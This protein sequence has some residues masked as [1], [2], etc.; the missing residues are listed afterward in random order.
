MITLAG[1]LAT[2]LIL[3]GVD[4]RVCN[5]DLDEDCYEADV[6]RLCAIDEGVTKL[7]VR[8]VRSDSIYMT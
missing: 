8:T 2:V 6:E 7:T 4:G 1:L 5:E 3:A